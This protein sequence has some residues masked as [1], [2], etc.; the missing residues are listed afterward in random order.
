MI[1]YLVFEAPGGPDRDHRS[2]RF[3]ADRFAW[4]ALFF[5]WLWFLIH[6]VWWVAIAVIVLQLAAGQVSQLEG[7]AVTG[8]LMAVAIGLIAGFEGRTILQNNLTAKGWTLKQ[9]V[10][11]PSLSAAEEMYFSDIPA[12]EQPTTSISRPEWKTRNNVGGYM[13]NDPAG[14]FQ[15]DLNGRR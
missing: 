6:R 9:I 12:D 7:F 14:S 10:V 5:P 15:F 1:S 8:I 4:L 11:A 2:T 3:V 13:T